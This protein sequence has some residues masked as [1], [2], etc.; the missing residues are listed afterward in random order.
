VSPPVA[1]P[2]GWPFSA[3]RFRGVKRRAAH[4]VL[5][6]ESFY[7]LPT[8]LVARDQFGPE[9]PPFRLPCLVSHVTTMCRNLRP[10]QWCSQDAY[11]QSTTPGSGVS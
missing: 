4:S 5:L 1:K 9:L 3:S 6:T 7:R 2:I 8:L 10:G 11:T